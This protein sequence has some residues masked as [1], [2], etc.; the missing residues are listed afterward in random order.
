MLCGSYRIQIVSDLS[1][2]CYSVVVSDRL[3]VYVCARAFVRGE[4]VRRITEKNIVAKF[5]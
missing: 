3:K 1:K 2:I 4:S 5:R